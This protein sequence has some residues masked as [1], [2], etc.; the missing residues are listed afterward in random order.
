MPQIS[1]DAEARAVVRLIQEG[2]LQGPAKESALSAL[3][4]FDSS[5]KQAPAER[6][7]AESSALAAEESGFGVDRAAR[8]QAAGEVASGVIEGGQRLLAGGKQLFG[9]VSDFFTRK[10]LAGRG[11]EDKFTAQEILR[12]AM[13]DAESQQK[14]ES[15]LFREG[16]AG[17]T[18]FGTLAIAPEAVGPRATGMISAMVR[19]FLTGAGGTLLEFDPDQD[20]STKATLAGG[21]A[22]ALGIIPSALP[23]LKN[24][25]GKGLDRAA[26]EGLTGAR[27]A[28]ARQQG[29]LGRIS[30]AQ[31]TGVPELQT[32]ERANYNSAQV[33]FF[34]D[35]TDEFVEQATNLLRQPLAQTRTLSADFSAFKDGIS[36]HVKH[37]RSS[38]SKAY[39]YGISKAVAT[40][41]A[42]TT[43][44]IANL[45][46]IIP[47]FVEQA[48]ANAR[49]L[50]GFP[51]KDSFIDEM[52][53]L[54]DKPALSVKEV[55]L[56]LRELTAAQST[57]NP[58]AK[59]L[60]TDLRNSGL[61]KDLDALDQLHTTDK[62]IAVL[63][64][65]R[66]EYKR[67]MALAKVYEDNAVYK[68]LGGSTGETPEDLVGHLSTMSPRKQGAIRDYLETHSPQLLAS[69]K[70]A[71]IDDAISK[72][73]I[74][75]EAADSQKSLFNLQHALFDGDR[76]RTAGIWNSHDLRRF[77]AI[78]D[79]LRVIQNNRPQLG[80]AGTPIKGEDI[81]T[82]IV[83]R[84]NIFL[85]RQ[86]TRVFNNS[87][88]LSK[89]FLDE[90]VY[91]LMTRMN[92][93]TTGT[94]A[95]L[96]ARAILL[97]YMQDEYG[98]EEQQQQ[99]DQQQLTQ[100]QQ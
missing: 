98:R 96:T 6:T 45:R 15:Q 99:P 82:N 61:E 94:P 44:P 57:S 73:G 43:I 81:T 65:T 91:Q 11:L 12:R 46:K 75:R 76:L 59:A 71:V 70:Q 36:E 32:L 80:G 97:S 90:N 86:F 89:F 92:R 85:T 33:R 87:R 48:R 39:D 60:V 1:N 64:E 19:N 10:H 18:Q 52:E 69:M 34:A 74:I 3:R 28:S 55:A 13:A 23:A 16:V 35:Q 41:A 78:K 53:S 29:L 50:E 5:T 88:K 37:I 40:A 72:T 67:S 22:L 63:R 100:V 27:L 17:A 14:G 21:T 68:M 7:L 84:S 58:V 24:Q 4:E 8:M 54:L 56:K 95:N 66:A 20:K 83:S 31:R 47:G 2:K 62:A 79:G 25:I 26:R 77:E 51:I 30:L 9:A 38:A 49:S 42:D 93:S